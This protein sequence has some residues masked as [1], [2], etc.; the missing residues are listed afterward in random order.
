MIQIY[1]RKPSNINLASDWSRPE[2][3]MLS[4]DSTNP[5]GATVKAQRAAVDADG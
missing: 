4:G 5:G 2:C 3:A 1:M